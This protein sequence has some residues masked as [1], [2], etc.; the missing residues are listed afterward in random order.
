MVK[1]LIIALVMCFLTFPLEACSSDGALE[2]PLLQEPEKPEEDID[3]KT[4]EIKMTI[5]KT[6]ITATLNDSGTTKAFVA[7]LPRT[8]TM[9]RYDDREYYGRIGTPLP[10]DGE[11]VETFVN[12]D[13][14]YFTTGGS[15]AIFFDKDNES[16]QSGLIRMGRITS[17]LN[18]FH[19]F[20]DNIEVRI[21]VNE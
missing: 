8:M 1:H 9:N 18:V 19:D 4:V 6:V 3:G 14:T 10:E 5:G 12:G 21:E 17:D 15:F 16:R 11:R 13:I 7:S 20:E 2:D